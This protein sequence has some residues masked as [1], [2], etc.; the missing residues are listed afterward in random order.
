M[1]SST[2]SSSHLLALSDKYSK[3]FYSTGSDVFNSLNA[4]M[5]IF[6]PW[7]NNFKK[8]DISNS[9]TRLNFRL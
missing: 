8:L 1:K 4:E 7:I 5:L 2:S 9:S 3:V 6:L